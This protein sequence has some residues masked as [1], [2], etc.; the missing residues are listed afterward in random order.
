MSKKEIT[1]LKT[2]IVSI[3]FVKKKN[4]KIRASDQILRD[5]NV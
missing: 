1:A 4:Q 5:S 3:A 2:P